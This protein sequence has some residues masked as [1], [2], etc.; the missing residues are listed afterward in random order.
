MKAKAQ[1]GFVYS[2]QFTIKHEK[3]R[4]VPVTPPAIGTTSVHEGYE[5][6]QVE[7]I[8]DYSKLSRLFGLKAI[9]AKS[10][11]ATIASGSFVI[12]VAK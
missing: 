10:G 11:R 12:R 3:R 7:I 4:L 6:V 8:V 1:S 5:D 2:K 9:R